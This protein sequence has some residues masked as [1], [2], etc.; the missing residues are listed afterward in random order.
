[1]SPLAARLRH[2][3]RRDQSGATV[4]EFALVAPVALLLIMGTLELGY[5]QYVSAVLNGAM[6][7]AGRNSSLETGPGS[8]ALIDA[9]VQRMVHDVVPSARLTFNRRSYADFRSVGRPEEFT[10]D[11]IVNGVRDPGECFIDS[12]GNKRWDNVR[13]SDGQGRAAEVVQYKVDVNYD[14][15]FPLYAWLGWA[16]EVTLNASTTLVNQPY[17]RPSKASNE[18]ICT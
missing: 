2:A 15:L 12:N 4:V 11:K 9:E 14:R 17:G 8:S 1:M 18:P 6:D 5:Q 7:Q 10:D 3:L 13:G 16:N